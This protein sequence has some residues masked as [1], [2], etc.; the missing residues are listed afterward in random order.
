M[1]PFHFLL[2]RSGKAP[3]SLPWHLLPKCAWSLKYLYLVKFIFKIGV[4]MIS[5]SLSLPNCLAL[6]QYSYCQL[7]YFQG[8][9]AKKM[10]WFSILGKI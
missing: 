10:L 7:L 4:S 8:G 1:S 5:L 3:L 6:Q 9:N 2:Q